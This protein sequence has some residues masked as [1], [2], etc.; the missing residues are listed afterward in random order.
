[1][2]KFLVSILAFFAAPS[3]ALAA[4][5]SQGSYH[6]KGYDPINEI[7][8][9]GYATVNKA[10]GV[11]QL[12]WDFGKKMNFEGIALIH[13]EEDDILAISFRDK[14]N[15]KKSGVKVYE[16]DG[17]DLKGHWVMMGHKTAGTEECKK[18]EE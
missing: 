17:D 9:S 1:M 10:S 15:P 12:T 3:F 8:Y 4:S 13:P 5:L 2:N 18:V 14:S 16:I 7:E 6:C 11:Y